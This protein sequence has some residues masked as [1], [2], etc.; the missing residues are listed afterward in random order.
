[1]FGNHRYVFAEGV[2]FDACAGPELGAKTHTEYLKSV[3]D[4]STMDEMYYSYFSP[5]SEDGWKFDNRNYELQ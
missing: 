2:I 3:I 4:T 5:V 1:V